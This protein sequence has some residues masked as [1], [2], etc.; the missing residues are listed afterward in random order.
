MQWL[1]DLVWTTESVP[2]AVLIIMLVSAIGLALGHVKIKG[3]SLG[4]AWVL[5]CGLAFAHFGL[6]VNHDVLH[7]LREFGLILF[8]FTIGIQVGPG[9]FA[10][11]KKNGLPLNMAA[12]AIVM[13]G[14]GLTV[15]QWKY[16]QGGTEK[17]LPAAVGLLSGGTTNT[18][19]MAAGTAAFADINKQ[20]R[21]KIEAQQTVAPAP[22]D[23]GI[24]RDLHA[25]DSPNVPL[26]VIPATTQQTALTP[27]LENAAATIG[28]AYAIAYPFGIFGVLITM[29][30]IKFLFRIDVAEEQRQ[31]AA[32]TDHPTLD[33]INVEMVNPALV[34]KMIG[35][36]PTLSHSGVVITRLMRN[37]EVD[38]AGP[39]QSLQLG[40]VLTAV[41]P[42]KELGDLE[43]IVGKRTHMDARSVSRGID[44]NR[45]LVSHK[46]AVGKTIAELSLREK[47][48]V[49]VTRILRSGFEL[50]VTPMSRLQF[51]D[52]VVV[53]G[54]TSSMPAVINEL[55]DSPKAL[56]KPLLVP[57]LIGIA[58]GVIFGS[59]PIVIPG[60]PA[61][62]KLGLAGGPLI[63]AI[64]LSR[65][66]KIGPLIWYIPNGANMMLRELGIVLFLACV[67]LLS[68]EQFVATFKLHGLQW[69]AM[70]AA[71]T[72]IPV[73]LIGLIA[74]AVFKMNYITLTGLLAGSMTDPP[75]LAF[76]QSISG[77]DAPTV[78]YATV[79][80]LVMLLRV[81]SIQAMVLML[82]HP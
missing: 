65:I 82:V 41:G 57:I 64:I 45:I 14:V 79:Y 30:T 17:E 68:G 67:G 5:F 49:Q 28:A 26:T 53:V 73:M 47:Y 4:I 71:I 2:H 80:P 25:V 61:P 18:P 77:S 24:L 66:Y 58:L 50:P 7:F 35:Q 27:P 43:M 59:I 48:G 16:F 56:D 15:A 32:G 12:A 75:A 22:T 44:V 72:I 39:D 70:G 34:G 74:R 81:L 36:I 10:S 37:G 42:G 62:L 11:L 21:I 55:G 63:I 8:V 38:V 29:L 54:E 19:S 23:V 33:A 31:L 51:G 60:L 46:Q 76:A 6:L 3:I 20:R 40:D 13:I 9:F 69:I 1:N 78:S 52:R